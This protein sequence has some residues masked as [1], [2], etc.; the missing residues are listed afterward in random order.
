MT[1]IETVL[2]VAQT[3]ENV[4][5]CPPNTNTGRKVEEYL[6]AVGLPKGNPWCAAYAAWC[7][8]RGLGDRWPAPLTGS[9]VAL[10]TWATTKN[11][12]KVNPARGALFLRWELVQGVWRFAHTGFITAE[13]A[14]KDGKWATIEGN[15]SGG[16]SREGWG[17]FPQRRSWSTNDRFVCWADLLTQ[18]G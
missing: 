8:Q 4:T 3:Q 14:D 6:A 12:L 13:S 17:V 10:G 2:F 11:V 16:G 15:T 7:G 1:D 18:G 5:E 9:C